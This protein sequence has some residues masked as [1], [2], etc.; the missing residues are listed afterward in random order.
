MA[1]TLRRWRRIRGRQRWHHRK[2]LKLPD[3]EDKL[4]NFIEQ[5]KDRY[6]EKA[7]VHFVR[8]KIV[9]LSHDLYKTHGAKGHRGRQKIR[10]ILWDYSKREFVRLGLD[11]NLNS[12]RPPT[13]PRSIFERIRNFF[14]R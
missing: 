11:I 4:R 1:R 3:V 6:S 14:R 7:F 5:N 10:T 13:E 12:Y 8:G 9:S 2:H